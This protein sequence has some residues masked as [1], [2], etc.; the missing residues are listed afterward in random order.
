GAGAAPRSGISPGAPGPDG[1]C[2]KCTSA[3]ARVGHGHD[4][5]AAGNCPVGGTARRPPPGSFVKLAAGRGADHGYRRVV[6][7]DGRGLALSAADGV[8]IGVIWIM[9]I[10]A[11]ICFAGLALIASAEEW[12]QW[13]GPQRDGVATGFIEPKTWPEKLA[14]KW[15]VDIGEGHSSP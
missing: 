6:S 12:P 15:Q 9:L 8:A 7:R 4:L 11:L 3:A 5:R 13:R 14:L 1:A 2:G 10:R